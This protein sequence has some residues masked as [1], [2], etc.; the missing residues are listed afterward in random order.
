MIKKLDPSQVAT[1]APAPKTLDG[2]QFDNGDDDDSFY[3]GTGATITAPTNTAST[4]A[5][6]AATPAASALPTAAASTAVAPSTTASM[7]AAVQNPSAAPVD[8]LLTNPTPSLGPTSA[9][10]ASALGTSLPPTPAATMTMAAAQPATTSVVTT[11]GGAAVVTTTTGSASNYVPNPALM[12]SSTGADL[13]AIQDNS[14]DITERKMSLEEAKFEL[15]REKSRHV[16]K[17]ELMKEQFRQDELREE[18]ER[19]SKK[20]GEHWM[21]AYWRP[22]AAWLYMLICLFDFVI[23]P[24]LTMAMPIYLKMLGATQVAYTQWQSLTLAN[25]GLIHLAFGAI[26][27]ITSWTRGQEKLAKMG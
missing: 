26:L 22:A 17:M 14:K 6:P 21:K 18:Q 10:P 9:S 23:G 16:M 15:D 8:P 4:V 12:M 25:G 11:S 24:M 3:Q 27:G 2:L 19:N 5:A 1:G 20:E 13:A 7:Q